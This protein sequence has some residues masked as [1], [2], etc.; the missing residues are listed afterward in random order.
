MTTSF[1]NVTPSGPGGPATL[2]IVLSFI[3]ST[4]FSLYVFSIHNLPYSEIFNK[5]KKEKNIK[6]FQPSRCIPKYFLFI[7]EIYIF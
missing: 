5:E 4:V 6:N 7:G 3:W 2:L 1:K